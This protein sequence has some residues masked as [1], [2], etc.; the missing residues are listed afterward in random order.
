VQAHWTGK[1]RGKKRN[2]HG[3][4]PEA[5]TFAKNFSNQKEGGKRG[6]EEKKRR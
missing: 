5:L 2:R 3:I 6:G 4:L 1:K